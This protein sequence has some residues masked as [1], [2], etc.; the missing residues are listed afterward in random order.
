MY[1]N[2][3]KLPFMKATY[4][5]KIIHTYICTYVVANMQ[6]TILDNDIHNQANILVHYVYS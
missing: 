6:L 1:Q 5:N 4:A 3:A 2:K